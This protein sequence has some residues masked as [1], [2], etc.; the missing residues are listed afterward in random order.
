MPRICECDEDRVSLS[1]R[2]DRDPSIFQCLRCL[3]CIVNEVTEHLDKFWAVAFNRKLLADIVFDDD[4]MIM[5]QFSG[6]EDPF[7]Y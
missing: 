2:P 7:L 5:G 1:I 6:Q 4:L 3:D